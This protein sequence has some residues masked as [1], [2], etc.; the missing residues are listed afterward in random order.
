MIKLE[1]LMRFSNGMTTR[2]IGRTSFRE[3]IARVPEHQL[4]ALALAVS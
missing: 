1:P 2:L 3:R 4:Y